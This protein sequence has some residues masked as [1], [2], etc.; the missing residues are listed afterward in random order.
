M[1]NIKFSKRVD[2]IAVSAI[3]Q[4]PIFARAVPDAVSLGQG[5][6]SIRTPEYIRRYVIDSLEEDDNIGKYSLQPG[7]PELK[8]AVAKVVKEKAKREVDPER[9]IFISAGAME[10]LFAAIVSLVEIGDE[11]IL[12]DPSYASHIEQ[13]VFAGGIPIFVPLQ[14][15]TGWA[16]CIESLQRAISSRTK[17][18]IVCNPGNP[19][20]KV[21]SR[22]ELNAIVQIAVSHG[23]FVIADEGSVQGTVSFENG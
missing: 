11:V 8:L 5:I 7:M 21:F 16:V 17:A 14:E 20:G 4:M 12:F 9:E 10:A 1:K 18:I 19:T 2:Q 3:K 6:P 22:E 15:E 23:L 13:V